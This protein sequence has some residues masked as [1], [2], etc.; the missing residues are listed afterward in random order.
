MLLIAILGGEVAVEC[1]PEL[2]VAVVNWR[3]DAC[4]IFLV[5]M[6]SPKALLFAEVEVCCDILWE[7]DAWGKVVG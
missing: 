4:E 7:G 1:H 2:V 6:L 5:G 3:G